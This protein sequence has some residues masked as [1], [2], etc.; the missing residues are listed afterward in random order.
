[1]LGLLV[2][3]QRQHEG[4]RVALAVPQQE[5]PGGGERMEEAIKQHHGQR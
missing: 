1:M 2:V 5:Q 3:T 4:L